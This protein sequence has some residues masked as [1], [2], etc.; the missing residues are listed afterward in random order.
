MQILQT[1][2]KRAKEINAVIVAALDRAE[3]EKPTL[4]LNQEDDK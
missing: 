1:Y 2:P 4:G 3:K